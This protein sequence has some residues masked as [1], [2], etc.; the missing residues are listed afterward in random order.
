MENACGEAGG[1]KEISDRLQNHT[2]QDV[3]SKHYDLW[4]YMPGSIVYPPSVP[5]VNW[6]WSQWQEVRQ[7]AK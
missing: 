6:D 5:Q 1:S 3:S 7:P 4:S 2:L